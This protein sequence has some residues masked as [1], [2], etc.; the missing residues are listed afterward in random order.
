M[1]N[2]QTKAVPQA[3]FIA[4]RLPC[5][6]SL[7]GNEKRNV[8]VSLLSVGKTGLRRSASL[9]DESLIGCT[10]IKDPA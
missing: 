2:T 1:G 7:S 5:D 4:V 8:F 3:V 10:K 6:M 9:P